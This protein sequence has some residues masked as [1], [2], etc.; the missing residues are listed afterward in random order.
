MSWQFV[1]CAFVR[2]S[3]NFFLV[4]AIET[5]FLNQSGP[6]LHELLMDT[7]SCM[8]LIVSKIRPVTPELLPLKILKIAVFDLVST[9]DTTFLNQTGPKMHKV[10]ISTRS[11]MSLIMSKIGPVTPELLPLKY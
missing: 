9:R 7:R 11:Q 4:S 1:H 3:I 5:T 6:N 2:A 8:S 10:F